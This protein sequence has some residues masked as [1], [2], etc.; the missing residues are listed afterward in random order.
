M[1]Y[2]NRYII[3]IFVQ[4]PQMSK[5]ERTRQF[6]VEQTAPVFNAKGYSGTSLTDMMQATGLTKGA[7]Y[8]N[9]ENK[10]A[11]ALAAFDHNF[12]KVTAY[13]RERILATENAI[14]RLLVY[15]KVYRDL[16]T[17]PILHYGCPILNTSTEAD[18][19]HPEL[20]VKAAHALQFWKNS[21][22][23][24]INRG[25]ERKEIKPDTNA[26]E[27][28][29]VLMSIVE[30]AIMQAKVTGKPTELRVA[31]RFLEQFIQGIST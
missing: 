16:L 24:Q 4:I 10:D 3:A 31:M 22:M 23:N 19:T 18:D 11:V 13:L 21:L 9:F 6:I 12:G 29:V 26:E 5:A 27:V 8:G 2:T 7:I 1:F 30:G 14:E 20:R 28:A 15:P 17:I 25:I